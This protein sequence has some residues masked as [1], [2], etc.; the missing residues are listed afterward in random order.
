MTSAVVP[1]ELISLL[2]AHPLPSSWQLVDCFVGATALDG[3]CVQVVGLVARSN[4]GREA[5]GSAGE[6]NAVPFARAFFELM[7]RVVV[8]ETLSKR[9]VIHPLL[10][11][12]GVSVDAA[13][14]FPSAPADVSYRYARSNGVAAGSDW[15]G[16]CAAARAELIE[17]DRILRSWY[18]LSVPE[19]LPLPDEPALV[20]LAPY[21]D[22]AL[23][24]F[25][26]CSAAG[27][28]LHVLALFGFPRQSS[29]PLIAGSGAG[30]TRVAAWQRAFGECLQRWAFLWDESIPDAEPTFAPTAEYHQELFLWP[31]MHD[32]LRAWLAGEHASDC[33]RASIQRREEARM[34]FLNLGGGSSANLT[35][36]QAVSTAALPLVFGRGHP[37]VIGELSAEL[38]VHPIA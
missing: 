28:Q 11:E 22:F 32:A 7:E 37:D 26:S 34:S 29:A 14:K 24:G 35:V 5:I 15:S 3:L 33:L 10:D 9:D 23:Y 25:P 17:R 20:S 12:D 4:D 6:R 27:D 19:P 38:A 1:P 21:Y 18:G 31:V 36:V 16:A 30:E 8:L 2:S 13:W